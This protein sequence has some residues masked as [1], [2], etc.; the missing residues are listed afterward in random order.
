MATVNNRIK[1]IQANTINGVAAG[2]TIRANI[3]QGYDNILRSSPDGLQGPPIRDREIEFTRGNVVTQDWLHMIELLIGAV[4][5]EVFYQVMSGVAGPN[6]YRK[7]TIVNPVIHNA[8]ITF[9]QGRYAECSYDFECKAADETKGFLDMWTKL[10]AQVAPTYVS[11]ARGGWRI[12]S[13]THGALNV[14]HVMGFD[15]A[16][17]LR[18]RRASNDG[19]K[20]YTAVDADVEGMTCGGSLRFQDSAL[21]AGNSIDQKLAAAARGN[22]VLVVKQSA[23]AASKTI[24]IAGVE[25]DNVSKDSDPNNE[26]DE[27]SGAYEVANDSG[28]PLTLAGTNKI[29]TIV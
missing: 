15:F 21:T 27:F 16:I 9:D 12:V 7:H 17:G 5:T 26:Y 28:T 10:D 23:G 14:Y 24:T 3:I 20:A 2:G 29:I 18:M 8:V 6:N 1:I 11:A 22:L 25:F 13:C 19:D 4:D